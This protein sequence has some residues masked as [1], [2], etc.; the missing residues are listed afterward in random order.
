MVETCCLLRLAAASGRPLLRRRRARVASGARRPIERSVALLA[1]AR[2]R[3]VALLG[4]C[5]SRWLRPVASR[6]TSAWRRR[7]AAVPAIA[8]GGRGTLVRPGRGGPLG[9][10]SGPIRRRRLI[11]PR[12]RRA[13]PGRCG[14]RARRSVR[15]PRGRGRRPLVG[16]H[17]PIVRSAWP[18]AGVGRLALPVLPAPRSRGRPRARLVDPDVVL[19][20]EAVVVVVVV[21]DD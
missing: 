3:T 5:D 10:S 18:R 11:R 20:R 1:R 9:R 8:L 17:P 4:R 15:R 7:C 12:W 19:V 21:D 2:E 13:P 16:A 14:A 6:G